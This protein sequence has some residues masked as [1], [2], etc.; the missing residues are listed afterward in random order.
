MRVDP[1]PE[2]HLGA[3]DVADAG[4]DLLVAADN[5]EITGPDTLDGKKL[6]S[7]TGSTSADNVKKEVP[8]VNLQEFDTYSLFVEALRN[9]AVDAVTTDDAILRGY[10]KQ[11][12][13]EFKVVGK[14]FTEEPYGVGLPKDDKALRDAV[15]DALEKGMDDG[16]WKKAFEYTL[17]STDD[18]EMPEVDRY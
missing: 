4:Q 14:P 6:C 12:E 18:V 17:G 15:N 8:G 10:A 1:G 9:G 5:T 2:E 16:D 3:V 13:G 7:V 11:Y